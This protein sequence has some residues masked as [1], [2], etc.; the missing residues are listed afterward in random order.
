MKFPQTAPVRATDAMLALSVFFASLA[1]A[2]VFDGLGFE[3][4]RAQPPWF[5]F[6]ALVGLGVL[7][8][9]WSSGSPTTNKP[10][11]NLS[12]PSTSPGQSTGAGFP[13]VGDD[14]RV[15]GVNEGSVA[16]GRL[17]ARA[18]QA[19]PIEWNFSQLFSYGSGT[20]GFWVTHFRIGGRNR[21]GEPLVNVRARVVTQIG[22]E[23]APLLFH[24]DS[25]ERVDTADMI[26]EPDAVFVLSA[27]I[28]SPPHAHGSFGY[29]AAEYLKKVGG[30]EFIFEADDVE[31]KRKFGFA[32]VKAMVLAAEDS[33]GPKPPTP[34]VRR[35]Q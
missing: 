15:T 4:L 10:P 22:G 3:W 12:T 14:H 27:A 33:Y 32:E 29:T 17:D 13:V 5:Y 24:I 2:V 31:F 20:A 18:D 28:P 9:L 8:W 21:S 25:N 34:T 19:T 26:V 11:Q 16:L 6:A 7:A 35:R 30:F 1:T 23:V